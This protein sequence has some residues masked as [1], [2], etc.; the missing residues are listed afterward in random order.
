MWQETDAKGLSEMMN[1][2]ACRE[3]TLEF[4]C[5]IVPSNPYAVRL[6]GNTI[7]KAMKESPLRFHPGFWLRSRKKHRWKISIG[8]YDFDVETRLVKETLIGIAEIAD[9]DSIHCRR[10]KVT[11]PPIGPRVK[12][13]T[14]KPSLRA[15]LEMW[16]KHPRQAR[17]LQKQLEVEGNRDYQRRSRNK[18]IY[19]L[20][21]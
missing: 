21:K 6:L 10:G 9:K 3:F 2:Q 15:Q 4:T 20:T 8:C 16:E 7:Q 13:T 1:I 19:R 12:P 18:A 17:K 14:V 11:W 5:P